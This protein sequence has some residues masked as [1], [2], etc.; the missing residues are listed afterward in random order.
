MLCLPVRE[1]GETFGVLCL[2]NRSSGSAGRISPPAAEPLVRS[3][4]R[5]YRA[6][7]QRQQFARLAQRDAATGL[8]RPEAFPVHLGRLLSLAGPENADVALVLLRPRAD[9][10]LLAPDALAEIG[11]ALAAR[12]SAGWLG[13]RIGPDGFAVAWGRRHPAGEAAE[14]ARLAFLAQAG[15]L[16]DLGLFGSPAPRLRLSLALFPHD[17]R[18]A[19]SLLAAAEAGL[20]ASG[21]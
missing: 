7:V 4:A 6:A 19:A 11:R 10:G 12:L 17:G 8:L 1:S 16:A 20:L 14:G 5:L 15:G 21:E 13:G 2:A 18:D 3:L 9:A